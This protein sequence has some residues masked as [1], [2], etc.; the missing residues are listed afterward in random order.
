MPSFSLMLWVS[1]GIDTGYGLPKPAIVLHC[2]GQQ[3]E[4]NEDDRGN[5]NEYMGGI[6]NG[7]RP[8]ISLLMPC[9][10]GPRCSLRNQPSP[11]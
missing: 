7:N 8:G 6:H 10:L 11:V 2:I 4:V 5:R 1:M 3:G 9:A